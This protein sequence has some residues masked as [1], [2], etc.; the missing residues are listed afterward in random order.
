MRMPGRSPQ[1][2]DGHMGIARFC[3]IYHNSRTRIVRGTRVDVVCYNVVGR[4]RVI[5]SRVLLA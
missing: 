1:S 3:R 5:L 2:R 4:V